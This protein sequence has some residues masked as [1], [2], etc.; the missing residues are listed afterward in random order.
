MPPL[1]DSNQL[2]ASQPV[3]SHHQTIFDTTAP[4]ENQD[5]ITEDAAE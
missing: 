3:T 5:D 4:V 1:I 2:N